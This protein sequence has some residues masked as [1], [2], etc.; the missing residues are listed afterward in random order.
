MTWV[1]LDDGF[2]SHPKILQAGNGAAGLFA[3]AMSF[4]GQHLTDGFVP[5][6]FIAG[7]IAAETCPECH[8]PIGGHQAD[9]CDSTHL[10][11]RT[12]G[13][14]LIPDWA[15]FNPTREKVEAERKAARERQEKS[16]ARRNGSKASR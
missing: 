3:R 16:R 15:D 1:K 13:G 6:Q 2:N 14:V 7:A 5:D 10:W 8:A 9:A 11:T 12:D 4:S